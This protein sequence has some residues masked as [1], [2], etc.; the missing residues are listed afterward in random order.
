MNMLK[1]NM[2]HF[3]LIVD[4]E[5]SKSG[6]VADIGAVLINRK[7]DV[8]EQFGCMVS[9]VFGKLELFSDPSALED[10]FWSEQS[11]VRRTKNYYEM[12]ESGERSIASPA[13]INTWL[14]GIKNRYN[15][16]VTAYNYAFDLSHCRQTGINLGIFENSFCL[17][18][19][20]KA[21]IVDENYIEFCHKHDLLT[22]KLRRP[23]TTADTMSKFILG[24]D[25]ADEPHTALED[26]LF[27]EAPILKYLT[28]NK[29]LT[30]K[31]L[32]QH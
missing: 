32:L 17:M 22:K 4:S 13:L 7:G 27:Y 2:Q 3:Y 31:Q 18:K 20:A 11:A 1:K 24:I 29:K 14:R 15:P 6:K 21:H 26:A 28:V 9:G 23:S 8:L 12:I 19:A 30:R 16:V 25:L 10:D 5:T